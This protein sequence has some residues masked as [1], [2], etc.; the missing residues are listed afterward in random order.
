[1]YWPRGELRSPLTLSCVLCVS[2]DLSGVESDTA[3]TT[4]GRKSIVIRHCRDV[5]QENLRMKVSLFD[6]LQPVRNC[7]CLHEAACEVWTFS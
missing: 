5:E 2:L 3:L 4:T 6:L 7:V 1:M